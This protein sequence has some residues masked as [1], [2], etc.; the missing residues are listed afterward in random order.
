MWILY[1]GATREA[2][3]CFY[4]T[5]FFEELSPVALQKSLNVGLSVSSHRDSG[6]LCL[7][8]GRPGDAITFSEHQIR[9]TRW[10]GGD[11]NPGHSVKVASPLSGHVSFFRIRNP[12]GGILR[13]WMFC[14]LNLSPTDVS[15]H[16]WACHSSLLHGGGDMNCHVQTKLKK[17]AGRISGASLP[18]VTTPCVSCS[19][20]YLL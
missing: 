13:L 9:G 2:L 19:L 10:G 8:A 6:Y 18:T 15:I 3:L 7:G 1:Y 14:S 17:G 4:H 11:V 5:G 16:T 12:W 20:V